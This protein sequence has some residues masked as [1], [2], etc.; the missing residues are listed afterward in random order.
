MINKN[1]KK[2]YYL[3]IIRGLVQGVGFRPFIKVVSEQL[4]LAGNVKNSDGIVSIQLEATEAEF[5]SWLEY[6]N[7]NLPPN[8]IID[9]IDF[10]RGEFLEEKIESGFNI[11]K[12]TSVNELSPKDPDISSY[13][14]PKDSAPCTSCIDDLKN[15]DNRRYQY[16]FTCCAHCGPRY[17]ILRKFPFDR[18]NTSMEEFSLC[19][20]CEKEYRNSSDRRFYAQTISCPNCGPKLRYYS[21]DKMLIDDNEQ[22]LK[23]ALYC[24]EQGGVLLLKGIGGYQLMCR[25]D[26][27]GAVE[28]LRSIKHRTKKAFA[29]MFSNVEKALNYVVLSET[30]KSTL[31][32]PIA[33]ILLAEKSAITKSS[34]LNGLA[35]DSGDLGIM[36]PSSPLH[37]LITTAFEV[38][39]VCT[40]ANLAGQ[41]MIISDE[42]ALQIQHKVDGVLTHNRKILHR[43]DD[44]IYR[45]MGGHVLCMRLGRGNSPQSYNLDTNAQ[46]LGVGAQLKSTVCLGTGSH[47]YVSPYLGDL[48]S[49][50]SLDNYEDEISSLKS[51]VRNE[52]LTSVH[53]THPDF[54]STNLAKSFKQSTAVQ[55]HRAHILS[56]AFEHGISL[57]HPVLAF[58]WDGFGYGDNGESWGGQCF[59]GPLN[60]LKVIADL[61]AVFNEKDLAS[62]APWRSLVSHLVSAGVS[63]TRVNKILARDFRTDSPD[64]F[65]KVVEL[66]DS[67]PKNLNSMGR[68]FDAVAALLGLVDSTMEYEGQAAMKLEAA[69]ERLIHKEYYEYAWVKDSLGNFHLELRQSWLKCL[70]DWEG[71]NRHLNELDADK[72]SYIARRWFNTIIEAHKELVVLLL[73]ENIVN[74]STPILLSGGCFQ[75]RIISNGLKYA[76][77]SIGCQIYRHSAVPCNDS[78]ISVG[79]AYAASF[80]LSHSVNKNGAGIQCV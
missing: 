71:H 65:K 21:L 4:G 64:N 19:P 73:K 10:T 56:C 8:A 57:N 13:H 45:D 26:S 51:L 31:C 12:S 7:Y 72:V 52:A 42:V 14:I 29:V 3:V 62:R 66:M 2:Y 17:S 41:P 54:Y 23:Q 59:H 58:C 61:I 9:K 46:V 67:R 30:G 6:V 24:L 55:H 69:A 35:P 74:I 50:A 38:P 39:L 32:S 18:K 63:K 22:S 16:P 11:K 25:S 80:S 77:E 34:Y 28:R 27:K 48:G 36:L 43:V 5:K 1:K 53:D 20:E 79:Q 76:L 37:Y 75:N 49:I 44:S 40:S 78:G 33:P 60:N 15:Q 68:L 47:V 70:D